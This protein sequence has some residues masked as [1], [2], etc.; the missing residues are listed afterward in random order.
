MSQDTQTFTRP[1]L[2]L[3]EVGLLLVRAT[4]LMLLVFLPIAAAGLWWA[5]QLEKEY[6]AESRVRVALSEEYIYRP[7]V[8]ENLQNVATEIDALTATEISLMYSPVVL[9]RVMETFGLEALYPKA[10]KALAEAPVDKKYEKSQAGLIALKK[11]FN[12][13]AAPKEAVIFVSFTHRDAAKSADILN[14]ILDQYLIYRA[15]VF[16]DKS[17]SSLTVQRGKFEIDLTEAEAKIRTFLLGNGIS[18]FDTERT[19]TRTLFANVEE[20]L[21]DNGRLQS[22]VDGEEALLRQQLQFIQPEINILVEDTTPQAI[23]ALELEREELL[24]RYTPQSKAVAD[25]DRRIASA[26]QYAS[27]QGRPPGAITRGPNPTFQSIETRL[28]EASAQ[29]ASLRLQRRELERQ[30]ENIRQRQRKLT[31]LEPE[32][33]ELVRNRDLLEANLRSFATREVEA[34]SLA[35]INRGGSDNI[36]VLERARRPAKGKSLKLFATIGTLIFAAFCALLV[37]LGWALTR[38]GFATPGS[39]ERTTGLPVVTTVKRYK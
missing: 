14:E 32:W 25:I 17:V 11:N 33:Q 19:T 23:V 26:R 38:K 24:T 16:E 35:E 20:A 7:R 8:G 34:Q 4:P 29:A 1:R 6:T 10:A 31:R 13:Y 18:D 28:S 12:A 5:L 27:S 9:E 22:E 3:L 37:G 39:L 2:G 21:F 30:A 36:R 15:E